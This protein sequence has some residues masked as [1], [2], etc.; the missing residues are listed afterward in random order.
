[1]PREILRNGKNADLW[2]RSTKEE[3][4]FI[5]PVDKVRFKEILRRPRSEDYMEVV[6]TIDLVDKNDHKVFE[7]LKVQVQKEFEEI[8]VFNF[9]IGIVAP[10]YLGDP[11]EVHTIDWN[12]SILKHYKKG[13]PMP[14]KLEQARNLAIHG[15][16]VLIEVYQDSMRAVKPNGEVSVVGGSE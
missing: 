9:F 5:N 3:T 4:S 14:G 12:G 7:K 1:M 16:Y 6:K 10:C 11:Y 2:K 8:P 13:E 15:S